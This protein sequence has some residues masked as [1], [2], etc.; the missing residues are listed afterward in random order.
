ME[1]DQIENERAPMRL[2][3]V[4]DRSGSMAGQPIEYAKEAARLLVRQL[5]NTDVFCLV[6]FDD[7]L[8]VLVEPSAVEAKEELQR[9]IDTLTARSSTDIG[10]GL[11]KAFEL[12]TREHSAIGVNR[13]LLL[14]DGYANHGLVGQNLVSRVGKEVEKTGFS[15][16]AFGV[17]SSYDAELLGQITAKG[18]GSLY[19]IDQPDSTPRFFQEEF[20]DLLAVSATEVKALV[21]LPEGVEIKEFYG[22]TGENNIYEIG[23][24]YSGETRTLLMELEVDTDALVSS[25]FEIEV[26]LQG[27][28]LE[29]EDFLSSK[30]FTVIAGGEEPVIDL[31]IAA[32]ADKIRQAFALQQ[33][34]EAR[35][36]GDW[37]VAERHL[38]AFNGVCNWTDYVE[39][40]VM[41]AG[42]AEKYDAIM[43]SATAEANTRGAHTGNASNSVLGRGGMAY[44]SNMVSGRGMTAKGEARMAEMKLDDSD[45]SDKDAKK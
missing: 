24:L 39:A 27:Q 11:L 28:N 44:A 45:D 23:N 31:E 15:V 21:S 4:F 42:E 14:S 36:L 22:F 25:P 7:R 9:R 32:F 5:S 12:M 6:A 13:I 37:I 1:S 35:L 33:A 3:C 30:K 34:S 20:G 41:D 38:V 29:G 2:A 8:E 17:G 40:G 18:R 10:A 19:H 26:G 16:S 43:C